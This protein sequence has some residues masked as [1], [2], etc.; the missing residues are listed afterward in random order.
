MIQPQDRIA[1]F[2]IPPIKSSTAKIWPH[3]QVVNR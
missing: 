2:M 1:I 3:R